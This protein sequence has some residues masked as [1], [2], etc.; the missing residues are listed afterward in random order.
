ML[1]NIVIY[2]ASQVKSLLCDY[3]YPSKM[4][5]LQAVSGAPIP[6]QEGCGQLLVVVV[7]L[8]L[9]TRLE[10]RT[11]CCCADTEHFVFRGFD[12]RYLKFCKKWVLI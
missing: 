10:N 12:F 7:K 6:G 2:A 11:C 9:V 1:T 3:V 8:P 5:K 4:Y